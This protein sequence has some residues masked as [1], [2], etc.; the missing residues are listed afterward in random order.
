MPPSPHYKVESQGTG[1]ENI[2]LRCPTL[3]SGEGGGTRQKTC[4]APLNFVSA[5]GVGRVE[6]LVDMIMAN[7]PETHILKNIESAHS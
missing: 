6:I 1:D 4:E 2:V 7:V 3:F 5:G